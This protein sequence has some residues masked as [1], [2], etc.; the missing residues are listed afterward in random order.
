VLAWLATMGWTSALQRGAVTLGLVVF[1][2]GTLGTIGATVALMVRRGIGR[3]GVARGLDAA[4]GAV[5]GL[6]SWATAVWLLAGF[7]QTTGLIVAS[8]AVASSRVVAG[9][10]AVSPFPV[11]DAMSGL[12]TALGSAGLPEVFAGGAESIKAAQAPNP[13]IPAAV[14][15]KSGSVVKILS[16]APE[17]GTESEGSGWVVADDRVVTNAHVV[18]GS[19]TLTVQR[20]GSG[21]GLPAHLVLFDPQR[22]LAILQVPGLDVAPLTLGTQLVE[23][24]D[25]VVAGYPGDGPYVTGAARVRQVLEA[26]GTD[27]YNSG[28]VVREVYSLRGTVRPGN[29][30]GPL[31]DDDGDVVGV[32]FARST[33]DADTG[34]AL[35]LNEVKPDL[36]QAGATTPVGSGGCASE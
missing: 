9:I 6:L 3:S 10:N 1:C 13:D 20:G 16:S 5:F 28:S 33:S 14:N 19:S 22:D 21:V 23:G 30:G 4:G 34:Y 32:V 25:S 7:L 8:E 35:T 36:A 17:C 27:I 2:A 15:A 11:T 31:F 29:S 12:D 26:S 18:A 24:D